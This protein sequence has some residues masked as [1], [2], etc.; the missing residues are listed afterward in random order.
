MEFNTVD[1]L[2]W[3]FIT[4]VVLGGIVCL[5][6]FL[7]REHDYEDKFK[8]CYRIQYRDGSYAITE[9][10]ATYGENG[11][12][13]RSKYFYIMRAPFDCDAYCDE[14][15]ASDGKSYRAVASFKVCFPEDKLQVFAPTFQNV[16]HESVVET[17]EEALSSALTEALG[18]YDPAAGEE[19][20]NTALTEITKQ[21][22][23]IFGAY[24]MRI[25][26]L[27]I[28]ENK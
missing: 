24:L 12:S 8:N 23:D 1:L 16:Q 6:I 3:G 9:K 26:G 13:L 11:V 4:L 21:K 22:L 28:S 27:K 15:T 18:A 14:V 7:P 2:F 25:N 10:K 17:L 19:A 20:L 5:L